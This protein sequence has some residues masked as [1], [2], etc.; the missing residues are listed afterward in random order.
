MT[1]PRARAEDSEEE[2]KLLPAEPLFFPLS[3]AFTPG[4]L[5]GSDLIP[6]SGPLSLGPWC[7]VGCLLVWF[8]FF[9][10]LRNSGKGR[11]EEK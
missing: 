3:Q 1:C 7:R 2:A 11:G 8:L 9:A 6:F 4:S 10:E 5:P